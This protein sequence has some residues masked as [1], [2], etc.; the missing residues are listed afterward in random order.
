M[1][2]DI[3]HPSVWAGATCSYASAALEAA[4]ANVFSVLIRVT[5]GAREEGRLRPV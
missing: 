1:T 4:T 2:H 5:G 3:G